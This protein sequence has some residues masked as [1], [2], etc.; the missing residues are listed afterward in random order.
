MLILQDLKKGELQLKIITGMSGAGKSQVIYSMEDLG[1]FCVDNLPP[2]LLPKF[3]DLV[4]QSQGKTWKVALV[5]D[6]RGGEFFPALF[7]SLSQLRDR[8]IQ[9]EIIFLEASNET[10]VRRFKETRRRHP[11][12]PHGRVLEG[13]KEERLKL[14]ELRGM[15]DKIIDTSDLTNAQLKEQIIGLF[16]GNKVDNLSI[17]VMS[18][19]Y[20]YGTPMDADLTID[21]RF[22]P[23]PFYVETLRALT[24]DEKEVKNYVLKNPVARTFLRKYVNLLKFL[25]PHYVSEGKAHLMI[26][27]GCTGGQ[28]RS[29][30]MANKIGRALEKMGYQVSV[31]HRDILKAGVKKR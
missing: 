21:V 12:A 11:L 25:I 15:A 23:N 7:E 28:H 14:E 13:I 4:S 18:F 24:G 5:I 19:G 30:V 10:L 8:G 16:S 17:T 26:A 29:V 27:I 20:K 3:T 31:A 1:F 6:I 22:L 9:Y 2:T